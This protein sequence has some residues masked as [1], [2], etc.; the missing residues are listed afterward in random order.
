MIADTIF[1]S[2]LLKEFRIGRVGPVEN[3]P[4]SSG[5]G[6]AGGGH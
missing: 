5:R 1:I 6:T 3:L 4:A 2:D